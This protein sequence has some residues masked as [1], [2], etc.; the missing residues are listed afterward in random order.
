MLDTKCFCEI[1]KDALN[2]KL[3]HILKDRIEDSMDS[4]SNV[5]YSYH[6]EY[7]RIL[8]HYILLRIVTIVKDPS[9]TEC[10]TDSA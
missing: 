8:P 1:L 4:T 10:S 6:I 3:F 9:N 2:A 5:S 7:K